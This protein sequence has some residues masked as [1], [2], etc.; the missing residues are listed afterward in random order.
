M[1]DPHMTPEERAA[2]VERLEN[3]RHEGLQLDCWDAAA[4]ISRLSA[5]LTPEQ[6]EAVSSTLSDKRQEGGRD[7]YDFLSPEEKKALAAEFLAGPKP[8]SE[9]VAPTAVDRERVA[10][11]AKRF[12]DKFLDNRR[13]PMGS[14]PEGYVDCPP[15]AARLEAEGYL[16]SLA[17]LAGGGGL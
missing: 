1:G 13:C 6:R 12:R 10:I 2:L 7:Y 16:P 14:Y 8:A 17:V 9:L 15:I 4:E 5:A 3:V 11:G